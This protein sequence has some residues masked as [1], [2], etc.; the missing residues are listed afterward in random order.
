M[1]AGG[2]QAADNGLKCTMAF[3][4]RTWSILY[5]SASGHGTIHCSNGQLTAGAG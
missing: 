2:A 1:A 3:Q 5:K 4:I